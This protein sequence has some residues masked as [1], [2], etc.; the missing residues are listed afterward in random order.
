MAPP[1]LG[2]ICFK[3]LDTVNQLLSVHGFLAA[4][5]ELLQHQSV[6]VRQKALQLF[7]SRLLDTS[8][9]QSLST[10]AIMLFL[11]FATQLIP[12]LQ[13]K[14]A[15]NVQT[16]LVSL[17]SPLFRTHQPQTVLRAIPQGDSGTGITAQAPSREGG[18]GCRRVGDDLHRILLPRPRSLRVSQLPH[19]PPG[20]NHVPA[21]PA[22]IIVYVLPLQ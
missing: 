14:D 4:I 16:A 22:P 10:E 20:D 8:S 15:R 21:L 17:H 9:V 3:F 11:D 13:T 2:E 12:L 7:N 18:Q 1:P 19:L 6:S 5:G